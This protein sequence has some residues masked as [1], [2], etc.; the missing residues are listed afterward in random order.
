[1]KKLVEY[2]KLL[3]PEE[4]DEFKRIMH[5]IF[6]IIEHASLLNKTNSLFK[7][8][9]ENDFEDMVNKVIYVVMNSENC[10]I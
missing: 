6:S 9:Y 3:K 4:A 2:I 10:K 8:C 1:M 5:N 7:P